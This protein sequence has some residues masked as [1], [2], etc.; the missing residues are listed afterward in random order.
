MNRC[1]GN[2]ICEFGSHSQIQ[3]CCSTSNQCGEGQ[4]DC[5]KD[6]ECLGNL[7]CGT[8]N[9]DASK[10]PDSDRTDCCR[11]GNGLCE[12]GSHPEIQ[13]CCSTSNQCSEGQGDCD[14]D[15][16]CLGNLVCGRDNCDES[17][18]P[19]N[20]KTDCCRKGSRAR[21]GEEEDDDDEEEE[22]DDK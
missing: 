19:D 22:E 20:D 2:I 8:D 7:V 6:S 18:F 3:E 11:K 21:D 1:T 14:K 12:F 4:G 10:F 16:E 15:S 17:K 5:D 13:E 9:C